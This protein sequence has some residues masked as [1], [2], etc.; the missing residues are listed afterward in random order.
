M[1]N[2][3]SA[4]V[5]IVVSAPP[6]FNLRFPTTCSLSWGMLIPIP[7]LSVDVVS[8]TDV[9][10]SVHPDNAGAGLVQSIAVP[11]ALLAHHKFAVR[12]F[13]CGSVSLV[14]GAKFNSVADTHPVQL[15]SDAA[16]PLE[17]LP[18]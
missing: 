16:P 3:V 2:R 5:V 18:A 14:S 1:L 10:S 4:P 9:P 8:L 7:T 13:T 11:P 17:V 15:R 6:E 12:V